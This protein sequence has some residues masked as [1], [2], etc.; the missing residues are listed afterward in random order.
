M[1]RKL[2]L[3]ALCVL[4]GFGIYNSVTSGFTFQ[5]YEVKSYA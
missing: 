4:L 5:N 3:V 1:L 2:L